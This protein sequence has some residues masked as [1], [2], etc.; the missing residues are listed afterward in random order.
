MQHFFFLFTCIN[1]CIY[2]LLK[3]ELSLYNGM[4][5]GLEHIFSIM[6]SATFFVMS[7][8]PIVYVRDDN[9]K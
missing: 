3:G 9:M 2:F 7:S 8:N 1:T 5:S 4:H 6:A